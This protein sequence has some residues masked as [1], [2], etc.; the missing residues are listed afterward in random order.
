[1]PTTIFFMLV[2]PVLQTII[3]GYAIETEI[4]NI[5][6]VVYDLDG[7]RESRELVESF[8]NTRTFAILERAYDEESFR[9]AISSGR[10]KGG[11][12]IPPDREGGLSRGEQG[13]VQ[14]LLHGR[15]SQVH[16][17]ALKARN[18]LEIAKSNHPPLVRA[19]SLPVAPARDPRGR[20]A[21]PVE[22]RPRL[23]YN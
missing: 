10:A 12:R 4:E 9:R 11:G 3:F 14:G 15:D 20:A 8:R 19:E 16:T 1:E 5:P 2:V 22:M 13:Q 17:P 21:V 6:T 23:L 18:R 7:R